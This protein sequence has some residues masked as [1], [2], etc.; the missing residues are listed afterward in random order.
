VA[1]MHRM[2]S[3]VIIDDDSQ[4]S[5]IFDTAALTQRVQTADSTKDPLLGAG[6][7]HNYRYLEIEIRPNGSNS[8]KWSETNRTWSVVFIA[9]HGPPSSDA[10]VPADNF[11][12]VLIDPFN[13]RTTTY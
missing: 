4:F 9:E 12:A 1:E 7:G 6:V 3:G 8:L 5:T 11:R 10:G 2:E 13:S